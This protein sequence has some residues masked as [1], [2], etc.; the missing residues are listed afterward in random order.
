M[1]TMHGTRV[2][3]CVCLHA[4]KNY[5][6]RLLLIRRDTVDDEDTDSSTVDERC[7]LLAIGAAIGAAAMLTLAII[8]ATAA[9]L[10]CRQS[11]LG[12]PRVSSCYQFCLDAYLQ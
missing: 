2:R 1:E 10:Y 6:I 12:R 4:S 9:C 5:T 7:L 3:V 11:S 8:A